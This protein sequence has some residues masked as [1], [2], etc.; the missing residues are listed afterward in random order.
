MNSR[1]IEYDITDRIHES[2]LI[3]ASRCVR[4][5]YL[6]SSP[7]ALVYGKTKSR[8]HTGPRP[9]CLLQRSALLAALVLYVTLSVADVH[10]HLDEHEGDDCTFCA[11]S[12]TSHV[13]EIGWIDTQLYEWRWS[14]STPVVSV[15]LSP[16][17]YEVF[18]PRA[19]PIS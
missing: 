13:P 14:N 9:R 5:Q 15:S 4:S 6:G 16:R 18:R 19:P 17:L 8:M 1:K 10:L 11:I 2:W 3:R 7:T 12:E